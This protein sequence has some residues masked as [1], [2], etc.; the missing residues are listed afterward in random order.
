MAMTDSARPYGEGR[1]RS[2]VS[3]AD[4]ERAA[5]AILKAAR[6]PTVETIR[7]ALGGGSPDTIGDALRRFWRDLGARID[8]DPA[9]LSRMPAEIAEI[10]DGM[11]QRALKLSS[12]AAAHDDNAAR[13]RLRQLEVEKDIRQRSFDL[14]ERE[15]DTQAR[16][17]E[18][19]LADAR[20][21]LLSLSKA[22]SRE[23]TTNKAQ[24]R[25]IADLETEVAQY[26][27]QIGALIASAIAEKR[28]AQR[29][30]APTSAEPIRRA[31]TSPRSKHPVRPKPSVPAQRRGP[32]TSF[33]PTTHQERAQ[34]IP[35]E[36][37]MSNATHNTGFVITN[38]T[39]YVWPKGKGRDVYPPNHVRS[40]SGL[41]QCSPPNVDDEFMT[42]ESGPTLN[43]WPF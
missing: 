33:P 22:L 21:H 38:S 35:S 28:P 11:W 3:Y 1:T 18:R 36:T 20:D 34:S 37:T 12:E 6:R 2:N 5:I 43:R 19:A 32:L 8:G 42:L 15:I 25:R 24:V 16:E 27:Q 13:E 23:Q 30:R 14:R 39:R 31:R 4:V 41:Q 26:R 7:E 10:A 40:L 29:R 17:R 9:A